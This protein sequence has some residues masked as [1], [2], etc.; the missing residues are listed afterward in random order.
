M[1]LKIIPVK[2]PKM[3]GGFYF[4]Q[5]LLSITDEPH[6]DYLIGAVHVDTF[7]QGHGGKNCVYNLLVKGKTVTLDI[8]IE[9]NAIVSVSESSLS[10][11]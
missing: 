11:D 7:W 1:I 3:D 6:Q 2:T 10:I 4:D 8:S 9:E 5:C